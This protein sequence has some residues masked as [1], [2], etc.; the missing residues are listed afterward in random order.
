LPRFFIGRTPGFYSPSLSVEDVRDH[1]GKIRD[2]AGC[3]VLG[4]PTDEMS[5]LFAKIMSS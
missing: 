5:E 1:L 4:G 2:E 3:T